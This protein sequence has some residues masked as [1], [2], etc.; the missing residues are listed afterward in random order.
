MRPEVVA[1]LCLLGAR[2]GP[3]RS[4]A[5]ALPAVRAQGQRNLAMS[6]SHHWVQGDW[7][8]EL[9]R[10][11]PAS[12]GTFPGAPG[13]LGEGGCRN[14]RASVLVADAFLTGLQGNVRG[15]GR[16]QVPHGRRRGGAGCVVLGE[17]ADEARLW[18][19][20]PQ[21][22]PTRAWEEARGPPQSPCVTG[23][24]R[25]GPWT[26]LAEAEGSLGRGGR[27]GMDR[28]LLGPGCKGPAGQGGLQRGQGAGLWGGA[29]GRRGA[30]QPQL[31]LNSLGQTPQ[32]S[33]GDKASQ[34]ATH[35]S[36]TLHRGPH[37]PACCFSRAAGLAPG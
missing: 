15:W 17:R 23:Y 32:G 8:S 37:C 5:E 14:T 20:P 6:S 11:L 28:L 10:L 12:S 30:K 22:M 26:D 25:G 33:P 29:T 13:R 36:C 9:A 21:S 16:P 4:G 18:E 2:A 31:R 35:P 1:Q 7:S 27:H 19:P 3:G 24:P 34:G